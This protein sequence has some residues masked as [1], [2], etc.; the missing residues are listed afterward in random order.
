MD[1]HEILEN[2]YL[3]NCKIAS[4]YLF[5][6]S[7]GITHILNCAKEHPNYFEYC[8][9]IQ[10]KSFPLY[11]VMNENIEQYFDEATE[12]IENAVQSGGRILIHC[13]AGISR[14]STLLTY[15]IMKKY[16]ATCE[17]VLN[18]IKGI[19]EIVRPNPSYLQQLHA[20]S[21]KDRQDRQDRQDHRSRESQFVLDSK[22][23]QF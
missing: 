6:E 3:G 22:N 14:S 2:I 13:H 4:N 23:M 1:A 17:Q 5:L 18:Y 10:Y 12:F 7:I 9:D 19:R 8:S 20:R 21:L 15:Y 11:D 16:S